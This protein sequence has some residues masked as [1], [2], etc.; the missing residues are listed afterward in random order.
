[1]ERVDGLEKDITSLTSFH[2]MRSLYRTCSL[3]RMERA[4][5]LE[6]DMTSLT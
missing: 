2:G 4:D 3:H 5:G 1:M 6:K